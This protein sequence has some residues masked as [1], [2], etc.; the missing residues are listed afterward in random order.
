[1][2]NQIDRFQDSK[3]LMKSQKKLNIHVFGVRIDLICYILLMFNI[4]Q[5]LK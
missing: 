2:L 5:D 1:M 4:Q 3:H